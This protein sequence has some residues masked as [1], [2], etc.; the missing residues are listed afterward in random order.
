MPAMK[1]LALTAA[2]LALAGCTQVVVY[3]PQGADVKLKRIAELIAAAE[4]TERGGDEVNAKKLRD[5]A[6]RL[7]A[8]GG[9]K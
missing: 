5:E 1:H 4:K 3:P 6:A 8:E 2:W 7:A 9:S